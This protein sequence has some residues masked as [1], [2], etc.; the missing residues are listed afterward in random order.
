MKDNA[1]HVLCLPKKLVLMYFST[2]T[3]TTDPSLGSN[4]RKTHPLL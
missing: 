4:Y 2:W 1:V 3:P